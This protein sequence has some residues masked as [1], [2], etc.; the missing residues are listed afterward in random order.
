MRTRLLTVAFLLALSSAAFAGGRCGWGGGGWGG[1]WHGGGYCGPRWGWGGGWGGWGCGPSFGVS[2][3]TPAPVY[4]TAP[5]Y[6]AAPVYATPVYTTPVAYTTVTRVSTPAPVPSVSTSSP[7][8]A[9]AQV[10]LTRLGYYNGGVDGSFGPRTSKAIATY[11]VDYGLPVTGRLDRQ[12]R[13][14]LGV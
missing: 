4:Y 6:Y 14:S 12:T 3:V 2:V 9:Q 13:A 5:V 1:G 8:V 7:I 10:K 11:Q